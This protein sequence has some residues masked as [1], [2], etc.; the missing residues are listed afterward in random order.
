MAINVT[1]PNGE[2]GFNCQVKLLTTLKRCLI[3]RFVV[4]GQ[5]G[6]GCQ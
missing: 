3:V 6:N 4:R 1:F 2:Y 5:V